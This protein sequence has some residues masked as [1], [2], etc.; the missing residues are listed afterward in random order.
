M[1]RKVGPSNWL[2]EVGLAAITIAI[3][4]TTTTILYSNYISDSLISYIVYHHIIYVN[5][6]LDNSFSCR[7]NIYYLY[8]YFLNA[9]TVKLQYKAG[10]NLPTVNCLIIVKS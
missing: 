4:I 8:I 5:C 9:S 2:L 1:G 7:M 3:T 10:P 6:I